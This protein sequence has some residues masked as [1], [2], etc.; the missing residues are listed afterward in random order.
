M[1]S[2]SHVVRCFIFFLVAFATRNSFAQAVGD[3]RT[4][5]NGNWNNLATWNTWNGAAW[6]AP[7]AAPNN[8]NG[9][10]TIQAGHTVAITAVV[11]V[12]QVI[13]NGNLNTT[14]GI[15]VT[16]ANGAGVDLLINGTFTENNATANQIVWN[17]GATWQM[18]AAGTLIKTNT[19]SSNNWQSN[20]QGG[21]ATIPATSNWIIRKMVAGSPPLSTTTPASGS[22][23]PNLTIENMTAAAWVTPVGSSFTGNTIN[24]TVK[25]NLDIGGTGVQSVDFLI[26]NTHVN[27]TVVNGNLT[28]RANSAIRNYGTG[29]EVQGNITINGTV[30]YDANDSRRI[31]FSGGNNQTVSGTGT[32]NIYDLLLNKTAGST[33]TLNRSITVDNLGTF[34]SGVMNT[35]NV[36]LLIFAATANTAGANN[37]SY[38]DGPV[39]YLG[40][41]AFT[42]PTGEAGDYQ[43]IG[44]SGYTPVGA[45]WTEP[46]SNGCTQLCLANGYNGWNVASTGTNGT[47]ANE[48]YI[49]CQENGNAAGACGTGCGA[50]PSLHVG[51]VSTSPAAPFFCPS[52]D[53]GAAYDAGTGSGTCAT[54]WRAESPA[55]NCTGYGNLVVSFNYMEG[56][57]GTND[58]A[59]LWYYNGAVW[60]PLV[61]LPKTVLCAGQGTWTAYSYALPASANNNP[62]VR[63]GFQWVNNDDGAGADP[64]FA[65]DDVSISVQEYFTAEYFYQDPQVPYGSTMAASLMY[66]SNCEYWILDRASGSTTS[67]AVTLTWDANS[68]PVWAVNDVRVARYDGVSTWQ[69]E[70]SAST[71]GTTAAG[72]ITSNLV[73]TFSPFTLAAITTNP[74]PVVLTTF[75]AWNSDGDVELQWNTSSEINNDYF[76]VERSNE[77]GEFVPIG[78]VEGNGTTSQPHQYLLTDT[79]PF[80]GTN[81]YRL[82]QVDY[83][84]QFEYSPVRIVIT[85]ESAE[86]E[87]L[88]VAM[89]NSTIDLAVLATEGSTVQTQVTDVS[90]RAVY[91]NTSVIHHQPAHFVTSQL[92]TGIYFIEVSDGKQRIIRKV[93]LLNE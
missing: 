46:F 51:N 5:A 66:L 29:I 42:F 10:I 75:D 58:N 74:L 41:N 43:A 19:A 38:V 49:S 71:T 47:S 9:A 93:Q 11:T 55:V 16:L 40:S 88:S 34:T 28:V 22:V 87:I 25:G 2:P 36:N 56:G 18:G 37:T 80:E 83:N 24:A 27:H 32:F 13:V 30:S 59:L 4:V 14:T 79:D 63:I 50:D 70:G 65:V 44:I 52:G 54:S 53:C 12:D 69:N 31:A 33:V 78:R 8:T 89:N 85:G 82:R 60:S 23:Y 84:G 57:A 61:D 91:S 7:G 90:G 26:S 45:I 72:T 20:Y 21:I 39:R 92:T 86:L 3:Y 73:T 76:I 64:S 77:G 15:V 48:F 62:N 6:V 68:C 81:Y 17:A 67:T 1:L 35:T